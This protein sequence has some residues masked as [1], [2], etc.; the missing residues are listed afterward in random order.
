MLLNANNSDL[1][2]NLKETHELTSLRFFRLRRTKVKI[3]LL[4]CIDDLKHMVL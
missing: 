3:I 2:L 4:H 1:V